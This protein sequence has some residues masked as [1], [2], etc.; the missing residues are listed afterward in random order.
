MS[1][2]DTIR[3]LR[4]NYIKTAE[5]YVNEVMPNLDFNEIKTIKKIHQILSLKFM[6]I[7]IINI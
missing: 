7:L 1:W 3:T 4:R 2:K 6:I 5:E